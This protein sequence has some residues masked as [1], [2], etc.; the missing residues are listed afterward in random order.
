MQD[1]WE[2]SRLSRDVAGAGENALNILN[3]AWT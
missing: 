3:G 2:L 1:L